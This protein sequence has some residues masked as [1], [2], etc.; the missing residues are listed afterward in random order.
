MTAVET[1]LSEAGFRVRQLQV[2]HA[3]HSHHMDPMLLD[4]T[5][6][7]NE[8]TFTEPQI[9]AVSSMTG[10]TVKT[11]EWTDPNYWVRQIRQPV[12]FAEA[13]TTLREQHH[14]TAVLEAGPGAALT[15]LLDNVVAI[16]ALPRKRPEVAALLT[17]FGHL[18]T[19]GINIDFRP[20][21]TG[22]RFA[23]LPT[24]PFQRHH[25]WLDTV[26]ATTDPTGLGLT[27]TQHPLLAAAV[28]LPQSGT[29]LLTGQISLKTHPW[30][31]E[32]QVLDTVLLPGTAFVDMAA[33][34]GDEAGCPTI[35]ELTLHAPLII[36]NQ[37]TQ[38]QV[39]LSN[40]DNDNRR[41]IAIHSRQ[42]QHRH[43]DPA[44]PPAPSTETQ[45]PT[46]DTLPNT[47]P[48]PTAQPI[49]T[50]QPL[51][52]DPS[53]GVTATAR[54]SKVC[55]RGLAF[56]AR[57]STPRSTLPD[58]A[59]T[60]AARFVLHP[61]LLD[62]A[63][64]TI[65][66]GGLITDDGQARL[67]FAWSQVAVHAVGATALRVRVR[68]VAD[69]AVTLTVADSSGTP[70]MDVGSLSLRPVSADQIAQA[71]GEN[72]VAQSL[73]RTEWIPLPTASTASTA[74]QRWGVLGTGSVESAAALRKAGAQAQHFADITA[75]SVADV[76]PRPHPVADPRTVRTRAPVPD[77]VHAAVTPVLWRT[78]SS[79]SPSCGW[80]AAPVGGGDPGSRRR[81]GRCRTGSRRGHNPRPAPIGAGGGAGPDRPGRP[82][83]R[84]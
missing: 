72:G 42:H 14:V 78:S 69:D 17:A 51:R 65:G 54:S 13:A 1:H 71:T 83:P 21:L 46:P 32:H 66:L 6:V 56:T 3:F 10:H 74:G 27:E 41:T 30:L 38:L 58:T 68:A 44:T 76:V 15:T 64:H 62:A 7:V 53:G 25:Y 61:A 19:H 35:E 49:D 18:F 11:S 16:A 59:A 5:T 57:T 26:T 45:A 75:L 70:V 4:F 47:W 52:T 37:N 24:Y 67:P 80:P 29:I 2:S 82:R 34:A 8:L 33:R 23:D 63:L 50:D 84:R 36:T 60:D 12:L 77:Q 39:E 79:G 43:L 73:L 20:A 31:A 22:G 81:G 28:T 55:R 9:P 48:P 40:T